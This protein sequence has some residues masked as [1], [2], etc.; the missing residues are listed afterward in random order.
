MLKKLAFIIL[1][2]SFILSFSGVQ[3]QIPGE[4]LTISPPILEL[5]LKPGETSNQ[6]IKITNPTRKLV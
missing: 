6:I 2:V 3:A 1:I 5:T 4:G